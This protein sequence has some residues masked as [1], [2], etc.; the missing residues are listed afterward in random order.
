[1][2]ETLERNDNMNDSLAISRATASIAASLLIAIVAAVAPAAAEARSSATAKAKAKLSVG[3]ARGAAEDAIY[4]EIG[5]DGSLDSLSCKRNSARKYTCRGG[6]SMYTKAAGDHN[7]RVIAEVERKRR[8]GGRWANKV[9]LQ[10]SHATGGGAA[11]APTA[12]GHDHSWH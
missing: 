12:P 2:S 4:A 3:M 9:C 10:L 6:G 8:S 7:F 1:M 11:P 5:G